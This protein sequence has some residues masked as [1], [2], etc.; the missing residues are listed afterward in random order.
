MK[1]F[2]LLALVASCG[3]HTQPEAQDIRDSDGDQIQNY[4]ES[5][6]DK[7][8]ANIEE[9]KEVKG[10]I[11]FR[12]DE[13]KEY[14]FSNAYDRNS[15]AIEMITGNENQI[16][17]E[18][19]FS[20][21]ST[22]E[23]EKK[24]ELGLK[25]SLYE[26]TLEF[27]S[28]SDVPHEVM[29]LKGK[30]R[31]NLGQWSQVMSL[32]LSS[33]DL[34]LLI[35]GEAKLAMVKKFEHS[36]NVQKDSNQTIR[37]KTYRVFHHNGSET[38]VYY[39]SKEL[40]FE[41]FQD[42]LN[43]ESSTTVNEDYLFFGSHLSTETKWFTREL[44]SGEKVIVKSNMRM[45][46]ETFLKRFDYQKK[47]IGRVN[48]K[49]LDSIHFKNVDNSKVY[50]RIKSIY[51]TKRT[52][53]ESSYTRGG[54]GGGREGNAEGRCTYYNRRITSETAQAV[55]LDEMMKEI[56]TESFMPS[57]VENLTDDSGPY[58][59]MKL[60]SLNPNSVLTF[61][62]LPTQGNLIVGDY[63]SSCGFVASTIGMNPEGKLSLE[64]ES[65][66]EKI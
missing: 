53:S 2:I 42:L 16:Q 10:I 31:I 36:L 47:T 51:K 11:R 7:Y 49:T 58:W 44:A 40:S 48:G 8:V 18:D 9:L 5:E 33:E 24:S 13:L 17:A 35:S 64:V 3:K 4:Q 23:L 19:Y 59:E 39:V 45:L 52:F 34:G 38:Q 41:A 27:S 46:R 6:L 26:V 29:L 54:G 63:R 15:R 1:W 62:S 12:T 32:R 60:D 25:E 21:W 14:S 37:E 57:H 66:V 20:E 56:S 55:S 22:V 28:G 50:L 61:N 65:Y 30:N 43:I